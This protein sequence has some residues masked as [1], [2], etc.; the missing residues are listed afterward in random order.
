MAN[1]TATLRTS[2][3]IVSVR[4]SPAVGDLTH[5][6]GNRDGINM[7]AANQN[8]EDALHDIFRSAFR[9]RKGL[10]GPGDDCA[11]LKPWPGRLLYQTVDQVVEGVHVEVGTQPAIMARKL[12]GRTL[13]DLAAAGAQP[14]ALSWTIAAS[15]SP[16]RKA[17]LHA[18]ARAFLSA[19]EKENAAV[20]GGDVSSAPAGSPVVLTCTAIGVT[21]S[22]APGRSGAQPGD[23]VLVTGKLGGALRSGRHLAP[24][25]RLAEGRRLIE[26]YRPHAMMD[27][28]DG[29]AADLPRILRASEVG[30]RI[31]VDRLPLAVGL[32]ED[33]EGFGAAAADGEDYEL[34]VIAAPRTAH[35]ALRDP[36][37]Q[38]SGLVAIGTI[39]EKR[40]L[41]W[42]RAGKILRGW[43]PQ[44][45]SHDF[46]EPAP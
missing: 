23:L 27:L 46:G 14:W 5:R 1:T 38:R 7:T 10:S 13:S 11:Q 12:V 20:I 30:A 21:D 31:A 34:L 39:E 19:A 24:Q 8:S 26:R 15:P 36:L 6:L 44:A 3:Q 37:L 33:L 40:G 29:L 42:T 45:W 9:R 2:N 22:A 35:R 4:P 16:R 28:S 17:W 43:T 32:H 18:L 41:R 25:P